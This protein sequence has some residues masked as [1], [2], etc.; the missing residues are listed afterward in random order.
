[1]SRRETGKF[2]T[3]LFGVA[4]AALVLRIVPIVARG[5]VGWAMAPN[6]DSV[7]YIGL[8]EGLKRGCDSAPETNRTPGYPLFLSLMPGLRAALIAQGLLWSV[9]CFFVGRFA[10]SV[11]G[12]PAGCCAAGLLAA[13]VPSIVSS[14]EII[15]ET[16]FTALL[17]GAVLAELEVLR[18]GESTPK[19]YSLLAFA[20]AMF[21]LALLV[22]PIAQLV[23]PLVI[24]A[25][26]RLGGASR[27]RRALLVVL[28]AAGP[29]LCGTAWTLRNYSVAGVATISTVGGLNFF[30]YRAVGTLA[31]ASHTGWAERLA[32]THPLPNADL[33]A[34][35]GRII[36][37]HP[38][39]FIAMTLWSFFYLCWVPDRAPLAQVLGMARVSRIVDPGSVRIEGIVHQ[40][41]TGKFAGLRTIFSQEFHSSGTLLLLVALQLLMVGFTWTGSMLALKRYATFRSPLGS[42]V[43]FAFTM[44]VAIL[45]LA[46][47]PEAVARFRIPATPLLAFMAGVGWL[48][49]REEKSEVLATFTK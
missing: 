36:L 9:L 34:Q 5:E 32:R 12:A 26:M 15:S 30:Y 42:C 38:F 7:T 33:S 41:W 45:L 24:V 19:A 23:M 29:L 8:A 39:A 4:L 49:V 28:V 27:S 37:H 1:V 22:R 18:N 46:S 16:L 20:S 3:V 2:T 17:I 14:N 10:A 13:D 21:G 11:A 6:G 44:A 35:A 43:L 40:L 31:F 47:G 48:G 25:P